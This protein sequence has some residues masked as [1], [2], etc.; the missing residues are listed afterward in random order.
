MGGEQSPAA[1]FMLCH[2]LVAETVILTG[3]GPGCW[4]S[5]VQ[6]R[7]HLCQ[8]DAEIFLTYHIARRNNMAS[9]FLFFRG[10]RQGDIFGIS[11]P[12]AGDDQS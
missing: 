8:P 12:E 3:K 5:L 4:S 10:V 9:F 11:F 2:R 1:T 6:R 7:L